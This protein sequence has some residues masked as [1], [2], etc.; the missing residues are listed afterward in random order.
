MHPREEAKRQGRLVEAELGGVTLIFSEAELDSIL[1]EHSDRLVILEASLTWCRPCKG[2]EKTLKV[3][4]QVHLLAVWVHQ[5]LRGCISF[6]ICLPQKL[7]IC[8]LKAKSWLTSSS[9]QHLLVHRQSGVQ[10]RV[11]FMLQNFAAA[12]PGVVFL[13]FFGNS[14]ENCKH[15]HEKRLQVTF[16][17]TFAFFRK[18][19]SWLCLHVSLSLHT[20]LKIIPYNSENCL[21]YV[22]I[23]LAK[24]IRGLAFVIFCHAKP[25][26]SL[27]ITLMTIHDSMLLL[28]HSLLLLA[29]SREKVYQLDS[30][31]FA[32]QYGRTPNECQVEGI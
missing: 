28:E 31:S 20:T 10:V 7:L 16:T 21:H 25:G 27:A 30:Q 4:H 5:M 6:G 17:P 1:E 3:C 15:L 13:K 19:L 2:F 9:L 14:N 23:L 24:V 8:A 32:R 29:I 26:C 12:Y 11:S 22:I 18:G